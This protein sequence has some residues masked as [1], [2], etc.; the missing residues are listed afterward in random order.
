MTR[1]MLVRGA[2]GGVQKRYYV[3]VYP[4][5]TVSG[6]LSPAQPY[7]GYARP[8]AATPVNVALVPAFDEC[9]SGNASHGAPLAVPSCNP[10]VESSDYLTVGSPESNGK[11]ARMAG[12]VRLKVV[13]EQPIDFGNGDQGD[14]Q[15]TAGISDVRKQSD[16]SDYSGEL[17]AVLGLRITD[18]FNGTSLRSP[19]TATEASLGFSMACSPTGGPEGSSCNLATTVD[20]VLADV[21]REGRRAIWQLSKIQVFDGGADGDGDTAGDNTLFATQGAFVP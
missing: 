19:A 20:A 5:L 4:A 2:G 16:L 6:S 3:D 18:S 17:R 21:A 1:G 13:G 14:V 15:V 9:S 8:K 10:A 7:P 11:P 12:S